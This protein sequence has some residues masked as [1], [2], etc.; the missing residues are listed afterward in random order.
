MAT[1]QFSSRIQWKKDTSAN[2]TQNNP[3]LLNGEIAI[4]VTNAGQT[5]FKVGDG[6]SSYTAL[7]FQDEYVLNQIPNVSEYVTAQDP[8]GIAD[9]VPPTFGGYTVDAF[10]LK[11]EIV[12]NTN[13]TAID[14]PLSANQGNILNQNITSLDQD[15]TSLNQNIT[16]INQD[17]SDLSSNISNTSSQ[18][19]TLSSQ[20]GNLS[21]LQT[22]NKED[23]VVAINETF[24]SAS[25]GK[26]IIA[27]AIT[28]MGVATSA[29][30]TF[31]TMA[32]N[33]QSIETGVKRMVAN[34]TSII[35]T[36]T[37]ATST[38]YNTNFGVL[39]SYAP[40]GDVVL[41]MKGGTTTTYENLYYVLDSAPSGV[42]M[43]FVRN[44]GASSTAG[45]IY[46]C[47]LHNIQTLVN[48]AIVMNSRNS[49]NDYTRCNITITEV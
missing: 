24:T 47:V 39:I 44:T 27:T 5:R 30:D 6:T 38:Y 22:S 12:D 1:K 25:N 26:Q 9:T 36:G 11:S 10:A 7:P 14:A 2:W 4:V 23:L 41:T 49:S 46:S 20:I 16:S 28:G 18:I 40:N 29:S 19:N 13:S 21:N 8:V 48:I 33:I 17:I 35:P 43:E 3:V 34:D 15:I 45:R 42:T 31:Q 32:N 37:Y